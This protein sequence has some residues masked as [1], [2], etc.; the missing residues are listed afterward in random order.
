MGVTAKVF[1]NK[2]YHEDFEFAFKYNRWLLYLMAAWPDFQ[3]PILKV[4][5]KI[6][7]VWYGFFLLGSLTLHCVTKFYKRDE[8]GQLYELMGALNIYLS[9]LVKYII[10]VYHNKTISDCIQQMDYDW[11]YTF[12]NSREIMLEHA[13]ISRI[14]TLMQTSIWSSALF[15]W[16]LSVWIKKPTVVDNVTVYELPY[17]T[18]FEDFDARTAPYCF[19]VTLLHFLGDVVM[20]LTSSAICL[21]I[22][23]VLHVCGQYVVLESTVQ[24]FGNDKLSDRQLNVYIARFLKKHVSLLR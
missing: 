5:S 3:N 15:T 24:T 4:C 7:N 22:T 17:D 21:I 14:F 2:T 13:K 18:Y 1:E 6:V 11:R 10:L 19:Y 8:L 20:C 23:L 12:E 9:V 16:Y